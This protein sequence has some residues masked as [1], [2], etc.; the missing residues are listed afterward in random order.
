MILSS[1]ACPT[2]ACGDD[3]LAEGGSTGP[4]PTT[5]TTTSTPPPMAMTT[6]EPTTADTTLAE[7]TADSTADDSTGQP[8]DIDVELQFAVR[9]GDLDAACGQTYADVGAGGSTI[10]FL[11]I[12]FFVSNVRLVDD[13]GEQVPLQMDDDGEWQLGGSAL[14]DFEDGSGSCSENTTSETNTTVRGTVPDGT[15]TGV[16]FDVGLP[17]EQN[18]LNADEADPPL[19]T[20]AMFWNW[21]AGYKFVKIDIQND[22]PAPDNRWNFHLGSQACDNGMAGP[23]VPPDQECARPGRPAIDLSGFDPVTGTIVL[24]TAVLY[25]GEDVSA[26][27]PMSAPG[28]MSFMPDVN[29]CDDL[30]PTLGMDWTSGDCIDGCSGQTAFRGE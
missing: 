27:T 2:L 20:T 25:G 22:N 30:F 28:C 16:R 14:L 5:T 21:A 18:H 26:D 23:T 10:E 11:D 19:N 13:G 29:E 4:D 3:G 9:V 17:F 1:F 8:G 12:R 7:S 6:G 24:D 15:Y